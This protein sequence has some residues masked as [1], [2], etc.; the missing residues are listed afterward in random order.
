MTERKL[1]SPITMTF[2]EFKRDSNLGKDESFQKE[3]KKAAVEF[4]MYSAKAQQTGDFNERVG[5]LRKAQ[6]V[7]SGYDIDT[8]QKILKNTQ[9]V[10]GEYNKAAL[11]SGLLPEATNDIND[12]GRSNN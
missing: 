6:G 9:T 2:E 8:A 4:D 10:Q 5:H 7:L 1:G 3:I 11:S 12:N